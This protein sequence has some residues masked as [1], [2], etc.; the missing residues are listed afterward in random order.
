MVI[1]LILYFISPGLMLLWIQILKKLM[2]IRVLWIEIIIFILGL[3]EISAHH[4]GYLVINQPVVNTSTVTQ[5]RII[6]RKEEMKE[7]IF[8]LWGQQ[9]SLLSC[10][11][12]LSSCS[13]RHNAVTSHLFLFVFICLSLEEAQTVFV[14]QCPN[15]LWHFFSIPSYKS[16]G[17]HSGARSNWSWSD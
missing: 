15:I 1:I 2:G 6:L 3:S 4:K 14:H 5:L 13:P 7:V 16:D 9:S 10:I 11:C 17:R 8:L 12:F